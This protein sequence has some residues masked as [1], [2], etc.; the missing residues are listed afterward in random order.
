MYKACLESVILCY[1]SAFTIYLRKHKPT[2]KSF[3]SWNDDIYE[4]FNNIHND[5][6]FFFGLLVMMTEKAKM[7]AGLFTVPTETIP[8]IGDFYPGLSI[9]RPN[10]FF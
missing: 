5:T 8:D 7:F 10:S 9:L 2:S 3:L 1:R 6:L 4:M